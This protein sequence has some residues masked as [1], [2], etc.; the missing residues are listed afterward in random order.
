M[1]VEVP[2]R[3]VFKHATIKELA[4]YIRGAEQNIYASIPA[5]QE[6]EYYPLS[7]AQRRLY[8]L[9]Q[10]EGS[11]TSYNMPAVMVVEGD[12]DRERFEEAF[13][14]LVNRHETLRTSF[15]MI[16]GEPVQRVHKELDF[17]LS[18]TETERRGCPQH[19]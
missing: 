11:S 19:Q 4:G 18:Y 16:D 10:I 5:V 9:N 15:E 14:A 17:K 12:L 6:K 8:I 3:E 1:N 2:L 13:R 7:S